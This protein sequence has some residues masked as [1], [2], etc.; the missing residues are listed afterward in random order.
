MELRNLVLTGG[1][2][3]AFEDNTEIVVEHLAKAGIRSETTTDIAAGARS[4]EAG[5]FDLLTVMALRWR[6]EN[7]P[8]YAAD[9]ERYGFSM[10]EDCRRIIL[11]FVRGGGGLLGLH[12][13]CICFD[14]W[15]DWGRLLGG[16]W[17]WGESHH[18]PPGPV[19][20]RATPTLHPITEELEPFEVVD[21]VYS[22]LAM[23]GDVEPLMTAVPEGSDTSQP[24]LWTRTHGE[25][26]VVVDLLGHD[27][28]SLEDATHGR[29]LRRS[30]AWAAGLAIE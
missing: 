10:P 6:M 28:R 23:T 30:A 3:H 4:L 16:A 20:V 15:A 17:K 9:R 25:G 29:L 18:P 12:T 26:R 1:V 24:V 13:A 2:R 14:D 19:H 22:D 8:K 11:D 7:G 21:E 27:R 5:G